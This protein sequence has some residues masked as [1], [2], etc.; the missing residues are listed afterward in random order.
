VP[1]PADDQDFVDFVLFELQEG[2]CDYYASSFVVLARSVGIPARIA[3]GY[4]ESEYDSNAKAIRVRANNGH[5]WP[6]VFFPKYGWIQFEPTVIIDPIDWPEPRSANAGPNRFPREGPS[7]DRLDE[8]EDLLADEPDMPPGSGDLFLEPETSGGPSVLFLVMVG[9][10]VVASVGTG[11][12]YWVTEK[13]GTSGLN[14]I[15]RAYSRMWRFAAW[16][17]VPNPPDQTPYER[18]AALNTIVPEGNET[19]GRITEMY[20]VERFGRENGDSSDAEEQWSLLRPQLWKA[21]VK[22]KFS[23]FQQEQRHR[24]R[25][26]YESYQA[27]PEGRRGGRSEE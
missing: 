21:W 3:M 11:I 10:L 23:R 24:W 4:A 13:R 14:V 20:V 12:T 2:Y 9:L 26:F 25:D 8:R 16:L 22:K 1:P 5:S 19:V 15:E 27:G 7:L 17:G 18:A 6:E